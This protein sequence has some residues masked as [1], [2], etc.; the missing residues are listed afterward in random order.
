MGVGGS[1]RV[2]DGVR[3]AARVPE[4]VDPKVAALVRAAEASLAR[5]RDAA[6]LA[7]RSADNLVSLERVLNLVRLDCSLSAAQSGVV[8]IAEFEMADSPV[9]WIEDNA[10][11]SPWEAWH[12]VRTGSRAAE[13]AAS[14]QALAEQRITWGH[15]Q[16]LVETAEALGRSRT[17]TAFDENALLGDAERLTVGQFQNMCRHY[18]HALEP[19]RYAEDEQSQADERELVFRRHPDGVTTVRGTFES[20]G[21]AVILGALEPLA[22]R[23]GRDDDRPRDRRLADAWVELAENRLNNGSLPQVG[24]VRPHVQVTTSIETFLQMTGAPAAEME[25]SLPI[26]APTLER[27]SCDCTVTSVLYG[28]DSAVKDVSAAKRLIP[29]ATRRAARARDNG[30][31]WTGCDRS[32]SHTV[33]HHVSHWAR[34][35]LTKL[36]NLVSVCTRHHWMLHE[37]GW[38]MVFTAD[39]RVVLLPPRQRRF[40]PA[41]APAGRS[42]T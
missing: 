29:P 18:R 16:A 4:S 12:Q 19:E 38:N 25:Y 20:A 27:I 42:V 7:G 8:D 15:L 21:A 32:A 14:F 30:C 23:N 40:T 31:R 13:L 36:P 41:R 3:S 10:N 33:L 28:V 2:R 22:R 24:G 5:S 39:N 6:E 9:N 37:G 26:G 35:G 11:M 1:I 17:S 34:G